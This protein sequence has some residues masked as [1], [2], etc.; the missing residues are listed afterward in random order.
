MCMYENICTRMYMWLKVEIVSNYS[1][2]CCTHNILTHLVCAL[3][4]QTLD[5]TQPPPGEGLLRLNW[6][7]W[8][9]TPPR[10][11]W[12]GFHPL[13]NHIFPKSLMG[14]PT[15]FAGVYLS[16]SYVRVCSYLLPVSAG[17]SLF[18]VF[19]SFFLSNYKILM[20]ESL[21][22]FWLSKMWQRLRRK[23]DTN[24]LIALACASAHPG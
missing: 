20:S 4:F 11:A 15:F 23:K 22:G 3:E 1:R 16:L 10:L 13:Q 2:W 6:Y 14:L 7:I 18:C 5:L 9:Q 24:G 17:M 21:F 19:L 12:S 8:Y